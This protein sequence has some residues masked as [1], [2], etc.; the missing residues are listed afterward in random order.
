MKAAPAFSYHEREPAPEI[1]GIVL[2]LWAFESTAT[3]GAPSIHTVWPDGCTSLAIALAPAAAPA[4][5]CVGATVDA[6]RLPVTPGSR[7]FGV[8]FWP[9]AGAACTR[10]PAA[11]L[12]DAL[13]PVPALHAAS[14][15]AI[16]TRLAAVSRLTD[17]WPLLQEWAS[18]LTP[19]VAPDPLVRRAVQ[20]IA[21][22]GG[23]IRV[24]TLASSL[25]ISVRTLQRRFATACGLTI[26]EYARIRRLRTALGARLQGTGESWSALATALGYADQSHLTRE[27]VA[28]SG[29][30]PRQAERRLAT[31]AHHHVR[32]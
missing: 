31:I 28:L 30:S 2:S 18:H 21:G 27:F 1:A 19:C 6:L 17:G 12:R 4:L 24:A 23:N 8:R 9:D 10:Y 11:L 3:H 15:H 32:P 13:L 22:V 29:V 26:K 25:G 7:Y 5:L 14:L 16:A 20:T